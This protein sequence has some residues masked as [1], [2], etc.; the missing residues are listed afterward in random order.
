[1][2]YAIAM[3]QIKSAPREN[4]GYA[5]VTCTVVTSVNSGIGTI[6]GP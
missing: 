2:L 4:P 5:Y 3:G 1:M 6:G